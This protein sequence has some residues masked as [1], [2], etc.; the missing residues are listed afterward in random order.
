MRLKKILSRSNA[1]ASYS[2]Y[3]FKLF[4]IGTRATKLAEQ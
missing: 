1:L 4:T 3:G 2:R